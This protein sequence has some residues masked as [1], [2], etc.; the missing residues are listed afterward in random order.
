MKRRLDRT[1]Q[2][3]D[4]VLESMKSKQELAQKYVHTYVFAYYLKNVYCY[5]ILLLV[6][7]IT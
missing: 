2:E 4:I 6:H 3:A 7:N 1:Q 5:V